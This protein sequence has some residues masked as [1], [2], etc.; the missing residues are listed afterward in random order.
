MPY[1]DD[2]DFGVSKS[3]VTILGSDLNLKKILFSS[4]KLIQEEKGCYRQ[5]LL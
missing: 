4:E 3:I 2:F 5:I 1:K